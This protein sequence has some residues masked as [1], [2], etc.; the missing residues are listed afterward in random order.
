MVTK[1]MS[2]CLS[3]DDA[4]KIC[5]LSN[6]LGSERVSERLSERVSETE[7]ASEACRA[8]QANGGAARVNE[9]AVR[10]TK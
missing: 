9:G 6:E 3:R 5:P 7:R 2:N 4:G 1:F 10:A 8:E